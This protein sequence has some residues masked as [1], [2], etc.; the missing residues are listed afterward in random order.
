MKTPVLETE[1]LLLRPF[2]ET[3]AF[4]VF[5]GWESDEQV[6]KYMFW[7]SHNDVNRTI[8]WVKK[9]VEKI[10]ADDWYRF[11]IVDKE[12][13]ELMGTGLIYFEEEVENWEIAYNLGRKYWGKG[14][15]TE[16]MQR[17]LKFAVNELGIK[18]VVGRHATENP[19]SGNV[20][21]K[22]GFTF[23]KDIPYE[24][25]RGKVKTTGKYYLY[26]VN[27]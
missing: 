1:R 21:R 18:K 3:D 26:T 16:A 9:E 12:K 13:N 5:N 23:V 2:R 17:I 4:D 8:S 6:A 27:E 19:A 11:A 10:D 25:N 7:C 14:Y 24:C 22:L 15:T 20:M